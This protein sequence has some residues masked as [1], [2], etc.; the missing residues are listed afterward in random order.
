MIRKNIHIIFMLFCSLVLFFMYF[1]SMKWLKIRKED[2]YIDNLEDGIDGLKILQ[3]T[4]LHS[5][6]EKKL[7][8]NIW[9]KI[10][11]LD[12]DIIVITGD[13]IIKNVN[14]IKPHIPYIK[15]FS[16]K[17]KIYYVDGNHERYNY[18]T[19]SN[20]MK[21]A[22]VTVLNNERIKVKYNNSY[23]DIIGYRDYYTLKKNKFEGIEKL[24]TEYDNSCFKLVIEHQPRVFDLIKK[25]QPELMICGHTHGGQIRFPF[26]PTIFAPDQGFFP[27]YGYGWYKYKNSKLYISKGIGT[28]IYKIRFYNRP[29]IVIFNIKKSL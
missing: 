16:K 29:E 14:E 19:I 18:K 24:F 10:K 2:V 25:Y 21:D 20:M 9:K 27:K 7:N 28:N 12:F 4:D 13:I 15:Q 22:G 1:G 11:N 17:Y 26:M 8:L 23:F 3:I 6:N 5:N